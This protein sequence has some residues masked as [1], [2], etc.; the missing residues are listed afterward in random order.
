MWLSKKLQNPEDILG[1]ASVMRPELLQTSSITPVSSMPESA[2]QLG[3]SAAAGGVMGGPVGA[4]IMVGG[5]FLTNLIAQRAADERHKRELEAQAAERH[6]QQ[7]QNAYSNLM[8][9]YKA[10]LL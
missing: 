1:D 7:E 6:G 8:S 4:G 9:A 10:A 2:A 3:T 5:Q